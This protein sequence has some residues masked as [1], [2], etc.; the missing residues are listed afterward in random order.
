MK[1]PTA[2]HK[3]RQD[4]I[5]S[6]WVYTGA[7][8]ALSHPVAQHLGAIWFIVVWSALQMGAA[9]LVAYEVFAFGSGFFSFLGGVLL[10]GLAIS[11]VLAI[12]T[13]IGHHPWADIPV[14]ISLILGFPLTLPLVMYW[15]DGARPNLIYR[16]RF[17]RLAMPKSEAAP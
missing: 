7:G 11:N 2:R 15:A 14:W 1:S 6:E 10:M 4:I 16:H 8:F 13:L 12:L 17:G 3:D 9:L 5:E